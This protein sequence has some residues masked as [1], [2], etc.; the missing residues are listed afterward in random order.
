MA[1]YVKIKEN[2][3]WY[4]AN[5]DSL[6]PKYRG[7]FVG[8]VD[9]GVFGAY[10]DCLAGV[11]ALEKAGNPRGTFIV[12]KCIPLEEEKKEWS[13]LARRVRSGHSDWHGHHQVGRSDGFQ[14]RQYEV[15]LPHSRGR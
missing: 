11:L 1:E 6:L 4:Y 8:V 2:A 10:D 7:R 3:D 15:Y 14:S 13:F 9:C 12:H 5:L